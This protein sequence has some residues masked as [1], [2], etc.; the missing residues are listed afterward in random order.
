MAKVLCKRPPDDKGYVWES[1][2][3][4]KGFNMLPK[5]MQYGEL[6]EDGKFPLL[7]RWPALGGLVTPPIYPGEITIV[8]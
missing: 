6:I 1:I 5:E 4:S 8:E 7:V 3:W 2:L